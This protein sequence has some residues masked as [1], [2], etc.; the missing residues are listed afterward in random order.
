MEKMKME[1]EKEANS[2][3]KSKAGILDQTRRR[4]LANFEDSSI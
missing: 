1:R 2:K 4:P 3:E